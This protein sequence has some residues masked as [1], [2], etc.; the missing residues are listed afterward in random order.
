VKGTEAGL[1][2]K[3]V[4]LV[5]VR[6][7]L[8]VLL[9][10]SVVLR[11]RS[12]QPSTSDTLPWLIA[13]AFALSAIGAVTIRLTDEWPRTIDAQLA[14][15]VLTVSAFVWTTGGVTSV[16]APLFF[17]TILAA[18]ALRFR[19]GAIVMASSCA[20]L[21][22]GVAALQFAVARTPGGWL[23]STGP[24]DPAPPPG[25][26]EYTVAINAV[27]F[28]AVAWLGGSLAE[29][30]R[31]ASARLENAA[32]TIAD[33]QAFNQN[34]IDSLAMGLVTTDRKGRVLTF[35]QVA[36]RITGHT[37][38]EARGGDV[39]ALLQ[40]P[41]SFTMSFGADV[42]ARSNVRA[43]YRFRRADGRELDLG[44]AA[45]ALITSAGA[46]GHLFTFQDTTAL[47][48]LEREARLQQR[49]AAVGEMA[50]GIAHEIR[51]PLA[52][53]SG[54][55][56]VLR[57][58]LELS[59]EQAQ[60][61]DIVLRE[62]ERLDQT[63]RNFLAYARPQ[64]AVAGL[65]D[66][67]L[68]L[69]DAALLLRNSAQTTEAHAVD[70]EVPA[71]PVNCEADENQ[72]RQIVWNLATNGLRAMPRGGRLTL[73]CRPTPGAGHVVLVVA[74]EGVGMDETELDAIFQ[75]FR[76]SFERGS[77]LGMAIVH[78]IVSDHGGEIRVTSERG[79]GTSVEV[80]LP[81][82]TSFSLAAGAP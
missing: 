60:L 3:L 1:R 46:S 78:R 75:P 72:V 55:I 67:R 47:R 31:R 53:M 50:A 39:I 19:R 34:V 48:R 52:S 18:S 35:N 69:Q 68:V 27:G 43:D 76:G 33:L 16:L 45:T 37:A 21:Y 81:V 25:V 71:E 6:L 62:S 20:V 44:L 7:A 80:R 14:L 2:R 12:G 29:N 4:T 22:A 79:A 66:V 61:M 8:S 42:P 5:V 41:P 15:D 73:S 11:L 40:I 65:I 64:R 38:D 82:R 77:G 56:Q 57:G 10:G 49:M 13:W 36:S 28:F 51:N 24:V 17:L 74:D 59:A 54:S 30:I 32:T 23:W 9:L 63:I 70:V 58:E 26:A